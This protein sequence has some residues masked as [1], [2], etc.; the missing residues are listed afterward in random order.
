M[1][2]KRTAIAAAASVAL[3]G[4]ALAGLLIA[5]GNGDAQEAAQEAA[6][7]A[8]AKLS[9]EEAVVLAKK[10]IPGGKVIEAEIDIEHGAA[11]YLIS[12]KNDG[13]QTVTIAVRTGEVLR[14]TAGEG[15]DRGFFMWPSP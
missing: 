4:L 5:E 3:V 10:Q 12:I 9:L 6:A 13:L 7:Q 2:A 8:E 14:V 11:Y 15:D 1:S